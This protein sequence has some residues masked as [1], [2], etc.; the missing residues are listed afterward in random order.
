MYKKSGGGLGETVYDSAATFGRIMAFFGMLSGCVI[1]IILISFGVYLM[2]HKASQTEDVMAKIVDSKCTIVQTGTDKQPSQ[3]TQCNMN[4]SYTVSGKEYKT[5]LVTS[6]RNY[7]PNELISIQYNP[8]NPSDIREK[9]A[10]N[11]T[12][13]IVLLLVGLG[14]IV[15]SIVWFIIT[16]KY[17]IAA[18]GQAA[19]TVGDAI[20]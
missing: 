3:T 12:I 8:N 6:G 15:I 2:R 17:K 16:L 20:F 10:A 7:A 9:T 18:A 13:G 14:I 1:G 5:N 4:V 19:Y 11:K